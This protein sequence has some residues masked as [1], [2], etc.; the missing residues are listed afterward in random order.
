MSVLRRLVLIA[1][2]LAAVLSLSL[3]GVMR[4]GGTLARPGPCDEAWKLSYLFAGG[5]ARLALH[6][7]A[8]AHIGN[9]DGAMAGFGW[10]GYS[11]VRGIRYK[12]DCAMYDAH[13]VSITP[14]GGSYMAWAGFVFALL[15]TTAFLRGP[16]RRYMRRRRG[17]CIRCG[18]DLSYNESGTCPE[19]GEAV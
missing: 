18:Y 3:A 14:A 2:T 13:A 17:A 12:A 9:P 6:T 7:K 1:L 8:S 15:P 10:W 4:W 5:T 19:C 16:L 11:L